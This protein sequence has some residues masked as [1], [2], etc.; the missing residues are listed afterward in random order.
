[1]THNSTQ[2]NLQQRI[3][4]LE[5]ET[6]RLRQVEAALTESELLS[7]QYF[8]LPGVMYL[9]L[10]K[11]G[12]ITLVNEKGLE[13]LGYRREELLG[14][15]WFKTCLPHKL[16]RE[17][18]DIYHQLIRG[19]I[20]SID[21]H[22]NQILRKDGS[23]RVIAWNN[24][25][26]QNLSGE[27]VGTLSSGEDITERLHTEKHLKEAY[28]IIN[29]SPAVTFLWKNME[30][31]PVEFVSDNVIA[32]FGYS[33]ADFISG[34]MSYTEVV[35]TEDL[36]R[37]A[38]EVADFSDEKEHE[39]FAHE[40]YRIVTKDGKVKWLDDQ[41]FIRRDEKGKITHYQGIVLDITERK[42]IEEELKESEEKYRKI[43]NNEIDAI[44]IF[45][46]ETR[47]FLD[48]NDAF[49]KLYGYSREEVL[50]LT[51]DDVSAEPEKSKEAI[52]KSAT[53]GDTLI[54]RR[55]HKKKD[56]SEIT[57]ELSAGPFIWKERK[58][59]F[60]VVRDITEHMK[61]EVALSE[62]EE[63]YRTLFEN[64]TDII[65]IIRPDG[66]LLD[67]NSSWCD[68][69]GYSL[70]EAKKLKVFDILD[71]ECEDECVVNFNRALTE[72]TTGIVETTFKNKDGKKVILQGSANCIY[73]KGEPSYVHCIFHDI[74]QR[75]RMEE[76]LIKMHKLESVGILAGG[77]AHDFNN[78]LTALTGNLSLA[79]MHV[80]PGGKVHK[81]IEQAEKASMRARDLTQQL[82]TFSKGGKPIK[83]LVSISELVKDSSQ[84]VLRGSNVNCD[85]D[86][87]ADLWL[88]ELDEG[89][90]SQ[91]LNNLLI[92]A[93]QAMPDGGTI[94]IHAENVHI[95]S[96]EVPS[97]KEDDYVS[98]SVKDQGSGISEKYLPKIFDPYFS[99]KHKGHGLGLATAYSIVNSHH[100]LL[101]VDSELGKGAVFRFY[102]PAS[103]Q[104]E[105]R[106]ASAGEDIHIGK[107]FVL[108]MDDEE[109]I[110]EIGREM[111]EHMGYQVKTAS[112][113]RQTIELY[114]MAM[115][116]NTPFD[117]VI[118]DLT[119]P[120]GMGGKETIEKLLKIDP[121]AT[122]IVSSGYANDPIMSNYKQYGFSGMVPKPYKIEDVSKILKS[123]LHSN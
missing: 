73:R 112:D 89:Q 28:N 66:Q 51:V 3:T 61:A 80:E 87:P 103:P 36:E 115:Q 95:G 40:P 94:N 65:Q 58:V 98:V 116:D 107:G 121:S 118:M 21:Y 29:K 46:I 86:L 15:N 113:G 11:E 76:E 78:I 18:L 104:K 25:V 43:F 60:A 8:N 99:T 110:R 82:L 67:V 9:V 63:R 48:V 41:T 70:E 108:L 53:K 56:G 59:M 84:F 90:I 10:D 35:H 68:T 69:L 119:V 120:G 2:S 42:H 83:Q 97:L 91:V 30:G 26:L 4:E 37:V 7:K 117:A 31:W 101:E 74:T 100:G 123:L 27:I 38:G 77:I 12:N 44:S 72:G 20:E 88:V 45:D 34:K 109:E 16:Q 64:A 75:L 71:P 57:V 93:D 5:L 17:V 50:Q 79:R 39:R 6:E 62:S 52:K 114:S 96:N 55:L 33:A 13:I 14:K 49:L 24:S 102:L 92:N 111:L 19:E 81:R 22:E 106:Q 23:E 32:L 1:M 85:F 54:P 47:K 122:V 105:L